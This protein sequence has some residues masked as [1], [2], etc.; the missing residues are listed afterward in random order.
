MDPK[1]AF[2]IIKNDGLPRFTGP[3]VTDPDQYLEEVARA[4][5]NGYATDDEEYISGV[6]AV[7]SPIKGWKLMISAIWVVGF[8]TSLND[9]K[10]E[11]LIQA[12]LAA[13]DEISQLCHGA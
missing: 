6:R 5:Q 8:K 9:H 13:A 10:M 7:A 2:Q 12:T 4:R 1:K 3:T 11:D